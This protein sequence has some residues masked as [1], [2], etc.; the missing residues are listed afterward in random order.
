ML[1]EK[2][3]FESV[4]SLQDSE[5]HAPVSSTGSIMTSSTRRIFSCLQGIA[6]GDAIG[7]QTEGL[8]PEAVRRWYPEGVRGFEGPPGSV[9]PRY[10][11]NAK[12]EWRIGETTDDT[13]RTIAV[14]RAILED[15]EVRHVTVGRELLQCEKCVHPGVK[16]LW[17]FHQA[18][19]PARIAERHDG[20]GAAIRASP[21]GILYR[22]GRLDDLVKGAREASIPTHG[23]A[24][25]IAAAA[26]TAAAVSAA[27]DEA[28]GPEILQLALRAATQAERAAAGSCDGVF[29]GA[30]RRIHDGL[31]DA[32]SLR[33]AAIVDRFF[34]NSPL[35]IVPLALVLA[36]M[37]ESAEAAILLA[38]NIGGDSDSVAS[39][40]GGILGARSPSTLSD[41]WYA[42]VERVNGHSLSP[43][44]ENLSALRR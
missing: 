37:M 44:A 40:A 14:A 13:E 26:A 3:R 23:G 35:T 15:G 11:G 2:A 27:I 24:L 32:T 16:S 29:A 38:A 36:T 25:A 34:P 18:G 12:R 22:S 28:S 21:V 30:V 10:V 41:D 20:C 5:P 1:G 4:A 31:T 43:L 9:I 17:E 33:P 39:I 6:V 42:V 7:K 8:S 19:D